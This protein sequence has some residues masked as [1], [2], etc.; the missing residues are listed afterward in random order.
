MNTARENAEAMIT[1][2]H[3]PSDGRKPRTYATR[4]HK[5]HLNVVRKRKNTSKAIRKAIG[6]QLRYLRR[7]LA[8]IDNQLL[9][10][11]S[12]PEMAKTIRNHPLPL[13]T[14]KIYV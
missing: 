4:A 14:A 11:K 10:E 13:R 6:K 7:D 12:I 1:E 8:I 9:N 2:M 5:D 3:D